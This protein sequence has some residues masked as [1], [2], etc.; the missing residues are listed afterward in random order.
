MIR[1][2]IGESVDSVDDASSSHYHR[3]MTVSA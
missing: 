1:D 3:L 2:E